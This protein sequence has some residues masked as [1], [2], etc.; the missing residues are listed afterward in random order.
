MIDLQARLR[1]A[2]KVSEPDQ[3]RRTTILWDVLEDHTVWEALLA[4]PRDGMGQGPEEV[5]A[6]MNRLSRWQLRGSATTRQT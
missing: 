6:C 1:E 3:A 5:P 2:L 4:D